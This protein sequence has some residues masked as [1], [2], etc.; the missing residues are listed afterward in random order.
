[1]Q[2]ARGTSS[3]AALL[4][5]RDRANDQSLAEEAAAK[6][7]SHQAENICNSIAVAGKSELVLWA[8]FVACLRL[9][10]AARWEKPA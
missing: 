8:A 2:G 6:C 7:G 5:C 1:M 9:V 3:P 10:F 4:P